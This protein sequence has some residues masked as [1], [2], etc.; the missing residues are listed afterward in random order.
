MTRFEDVP[1]V[2]GFK[3]DEVKAW[4]LTCDICEA[5]WFVVGDGAREDAEQWAN[6]H[7]TFCFEEL[8]L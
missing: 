7:R 1:R 4:V 8:E 2:F 3:T 5:E 6:D